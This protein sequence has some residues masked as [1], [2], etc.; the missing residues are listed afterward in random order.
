LE[1]MM[2]ED[3]WKLDWGR[4][5]DTPDPGWFLR[6]LDE[7]RKFLPPPSLE[8]AKKS[9]GFLDVKEGHH[10]LDIGCGTGLHC[11]LLAFLV[12]RSGLVTGIDYSDQMVREAQRRVEGKNLPLRF[13]RGD[14]NALQFDSNTFDRIW[15]AAVLQ[16]LEDPSRAIAEMVRALKPGGMVCSFE[17]DWGTLAIDAGDVE[18]AQKIA[19]LHCDSIRTGHIGRQV[20][21]LFKEAGLS[22]VTVTGI[23]YVMD[24]L[25]LLEDC[26]LQ[27]VGKRAIENGTIMEADFKNLL[28]GLRLEASKGRTLWS[29]LVF[30]VVGQKKQP[31]HVGLK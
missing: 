31:T 6:F 24:S 15:C 23:P 21:R 3:M 14:A 9:F 26:V 11:Q 20:P 8:A 18:T 25:P 7:S 1:E 30:R 27:P 4:V 2:S 29:F 17:H 12:G 19:T 10:V 13:A 5:D 16:H 28:E 22:E